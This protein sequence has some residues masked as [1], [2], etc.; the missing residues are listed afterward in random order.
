MLSGMFSKLSFLQ[1]FW[2]WVRTFK[3]FYLFKAL[4][5]RTSRPDKSIFAG[6]FLISR[7]ERFLP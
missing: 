1:I 7:L 4:I 6:I 5:I 3:N 2:E